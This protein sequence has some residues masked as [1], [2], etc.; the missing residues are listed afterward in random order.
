MASI[1]VRSGDGSNSDT[2]STWALAKATLAGATAIVAQGDTIYLSASHAESAASAKSFA[3]AGTNA[4]PVRVLSVSDAAE[5]PTAL[6]A[7]ASV[8]T[9]GVNAITTQGA[10][11]VHGVTFSCGSG[12]VNATLSLNNYTNT[13]N[14]K[15]TFEDCT[16]LAPPTGIGARISVNNIGAA[17]NAIDNVTTWINCDARVNGT[18]TSIPQI[19]CSGRFEWLGGAILSGG[20]TTICGLFGGING[21]GRTTEIVVSGVDLRNMATGQNIFRATNANCIGVLRDCALPSGWTGELVNGT[22]SVCDRLA[23]YNC[24]DGASNYKFWLRDYYGS[25]IQEATIVRTGG[26]SD[27]DTP[28]SAKMVSN[29]NARYPLGGV[30]SMEMELRLDSTGSKTITVEVLTDGVTLTDQDMRLDVL[31]LGSA[32]TTLGTITSNA[33]GVLDSATNLPSS[34]VTWT[35][36]GLA[37]PVKQKL[38]VSFTAAQEGV[39]MAVVTLMK[40]STT[41]YVDVQPTVS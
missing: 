26:A 36:T 19:E 14:I 27:G 12:A 28:V 29:S 13:Y 22:L 11:Y 4:T 5:P 37:S 25:V 24:D 10:A 41:V 1:Y 35:T 33:P 17:S 15:E 2:G 30:R 3:F 8:T 21:G 38:E 40:P 18:S 6:S 32:S 20:T 9:T 39:V 31:A 16:F 23:M 34:S 7:G